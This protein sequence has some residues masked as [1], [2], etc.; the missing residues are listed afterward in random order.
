M[1]S[2]K[3]FFSIVV[4]ILLIACQSNATAQ[5]FAP[6]RNWA[7]ATSFP[8]MPV[9]EQDSVFIFFSSSENPVLGNLSAQFSDSSASTY[10]WF[11]YNETQRQF[12]QIVGAT[13]ST[14]NDVDK[15]GYRVRVTRIEDDSVQTYTSWVMID[16]VEIDRL[17]VWNNTCSK[18]TLALF[19]SPDNFYEVNSKSFTYYNYHLPTHPPASILGA[20][21]YFSNYTFESIPNEVP[22]N[23]LARFLY[24]SHLIDI[25]FEN[26]INEN[27]HGP[28][29]DAKYKLTVITPFGRGNLVV[30]TE[31]ITA[32]ATKVG[33]E[34]YL[35]KMTDGA[36]NWELAGENPSGEA[37]LEVKLKSTSENADSIYWKLNKITS[38]YPV[39]SKMI[40]SDSTF[41]EI[42]ED[43]TAF[44]PKELMVPG[45]YKVEHKAKRSSS[46]CIDRVTMPFDENVYLVVDSSL[47]SGTAI[48]NVFTP[49]GMNP[50]FKFVLPE[51]NIL[52]IKSFKIVIFSRWGNQVYSFEGDP[53]TWEGW[54]GKIDNTKGDASSGVY[55][56]IIDAEGWDGKRFRKGQYKGFLHLF[57]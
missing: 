40:W 54:N 28:L 26:S 33:F 48:P 56:F 30:E 38:L 1:Q 31:T 34:I 7:G 52:S 14:L 39:I 17:D 44:P 6:G 2:F 11:K 18:L 35:N 27:M 13:D 25:E 42:E 12:N 20:G 21:G 10:T 41:F 47:F 19:T 32:I 15:G 9:D 36:L 45:Y 4:V 50:V 3:Y 51:D 55:Y 49:N 37:L 46:G 53:K 23:Q 16:E 8:F 29:K 24:D 5:I 22:V 43:G 57:R